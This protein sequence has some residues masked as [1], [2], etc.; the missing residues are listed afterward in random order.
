MDG[1]T[2]FRR[3]RRAS[4]PRRPLADPRLSRGDRRGDLRQ[5][6]RSAEFRVRG[7]RRKPGEALGA[8]EKPAINASDLV[9]RRLRKGAA[10]SRPASPPREKFRPIV[11][12]RSASQTCG[13]MRKRTARFSMTLHR[14]MRRAPSFCARRPRRCIF[15]P[16]AII[17]CSRSRAPSPTSMGPR[18]SAGRISPK[19]SLTARFTI[20]CRRRLD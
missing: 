19:P 1:A 17:A 11:S 15:P 14:L 9:L 12:R 20:A 8:A 16:A 6:R 3:R 7:L 13:S 18:Q 5:A 4:V 2:I 10:R